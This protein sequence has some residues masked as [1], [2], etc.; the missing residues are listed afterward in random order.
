M[1]GIID[2]IN[3]VRRDLEQITATMQG[4]I[5]RNRLVFSVLDKIDADIA[6]LDDAN[7]GDRGGT[8]VILAAATQ[9]ATGSPDRLAAQEAGAATRQAASA[10]AEQA[11]GAE[12]L[13]AAI[14]EIASL[15]DE[16][17]QSNG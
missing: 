5:E 12:D 1:R 17:K 9:A 14:E 2:Q 3:A 10:S 11:R 13:A 16:L 7:G 4:D 6:S 8:E 15:A